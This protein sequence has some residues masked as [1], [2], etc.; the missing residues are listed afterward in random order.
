MELTSSP[1]DSPVTMSDGRVN[2]D[3]IRI[4]T[5]T[6]TPSRSEI[7]PVGKVSIAMAAIAKPTRGTA[8]F[9]RRC[10]GLSKSRHHQGYQEAHSEGN[11]VSC[12][13]CCKLYEPVCG[14][15][16]NGVFN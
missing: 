11:H 6:V 14:T 9:I 4:Q 16:E 7:L 13:S 1:D 10:I 2:A 12:R 5:L 15:S 8:D 3:Q